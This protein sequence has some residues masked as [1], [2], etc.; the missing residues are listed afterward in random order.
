MDRINNSSVSDM[1]QAVESGDLDLDQFGDGFFD[2]FGSEEV[3]GKIEET[4][5]IIDTTS[6]AK[7]DLQNL[8]T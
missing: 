3:R 8:A 5:N 7:D 6:R 4:R 1:V 2:D